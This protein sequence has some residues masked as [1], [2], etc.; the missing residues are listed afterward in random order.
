M[1]IKTSKTKSISDQVVLFTQTIE[2]SFEDKKKAG[3]AFVNLTAAYD[4]VWNHGLTCKLL[5][6]LPK[7]QMVRM[8]MKLV[9]N[10]SFSVTTG[11]NKQSRLCRLKNGVLWDLSWM[12]AFQHL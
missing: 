12:S 3:A 10:R 4:T 7:K 11:D 5:T 6:I 9:Q 8:V 2:D 1:K